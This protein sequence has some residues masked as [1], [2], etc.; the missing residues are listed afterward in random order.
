MTEFY[1]RYYPT[2]CIRRAEMKALEHLP[3]SEKELMLPVVLLAPWLNSIEFENT[4]KIVAKS[5]EGTR[6]IVDLDRHFRSDSDLP[7]RTFF[8]GLLS[9]DEGALTWMD[10]VT[11]HENYIPTIQFSGI[12]DEIVQKQIER[13]KELGRGFVFRCELQL[14]H[15]I[16]RILSFV[17]ENKE[18][19]ILTI[20]DYGY[21]DD[22]LELTN[23][24]ASHVRSI[25][26]IEDSLKFVITG[27]NFP[28][29]FSDF[30][31]FSTAKSIG[32]R[33]T[34]RELSRLFD[35]YQIFYGDWASTKPRRYDGGGNKPLPRID[36]PTKSQWIIARSKEEEWSFQEAAERV[37][38][39][40]EWSDR[41]MVWGAGLIEKTARGLP[42]GISTGPQSIAARVNIHLYQQNHFKTDGLPPIPEGEWVDPI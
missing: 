32:A 3:L 14:E 17:A 30:D 2:V 28:N 38:R 13:A 12:S 22:N 40:E 20:I 34:Y 1:D 23:L 27:A 37:T 8:R 33:I 35:N 6:I 18:E 31:E 5:L 36:Y 4:H 10:L 15:D 26:E 19:D 9:G 25:V 11:Q 42:G 41:P 29:S 16:K 7:S 39:L 24:I 21:Q